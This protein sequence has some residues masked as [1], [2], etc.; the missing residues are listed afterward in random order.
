MRG[1]RLASCLLVAVADGCRAVIVLL[2][3][4]PDFT[5][6]EVALVFL[7]DGK[8]LDGKASPTES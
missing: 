1:K 7:Q 4:D 3:I 2:G 6:K 5:D 8:P